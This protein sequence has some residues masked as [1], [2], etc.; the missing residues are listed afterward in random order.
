MT[1]HSK[2]SPS[3]RARWGACP[4][5]V[6]EEARY[7]DQPSGAAA[8]DGTHSHTLL[9]TCL[10]NMGITGHIADPKV[11]V[12][13]NLKDDDGEFVVDAERAE[14]VQFAIDYIK[15]RMALDPLCQVISET[16]VHPDSLVLR[17][18]M[19]GTVDVQIL[20]GD[21]TGIEII[22]YKDGM[23]VV[24][25]AGNPQL[26]QYAVGVIAQILDKAQLAPM[27]VRLTIIQ[28]KLR[29]KGMSGISYSDTTL[30]ALMQAKDKMIVEAAATEAPDAPLVPG[31]TQCK[32]CAHKG[33]CPA[34]TGQALAASGIVFQNLDVSKQAAD[35]DPSK[36]TDAQ[37][38]EIMESA[39]LLRQMIEAVETEAQ[40][41][42]DS[43]VVIAGLKLVNGR[44]ARSWNVSED[45]IAAKLKK[46]GVP[47]DS[48]YVSKLV[49]PAQS[50]KLSWQKGEETVKLS[51]RQM[52][53]M[54]EFI[55]TTVGK[56]VIALASDA[57][58]AVTISAAA[59]FP[60][61]DHSES[62]PSWLS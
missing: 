40:R 16:R 20:S 56:P 49:S 25:A 7:P 26:E 19:N 4:G 8:V 36:M 54:K 59:M 53:Q 2:L 27:R 13:T 51:D 50:E 12:G 28:P 29:L 10:G 33:S 24:E 41:R 1:T 3:A 44:G 57:R 21:G 47:K 31:E 43:G 18:D 45:D 42:L 48:I 14:R 37:I 35:K 17:D 60:A 23:G 15:S 9:E 62:I 55:S 61:V 5:S 32:F 52:S 30:G 34:L 46:M 38:V 11:F 22:D 58:K 6:R 39:P